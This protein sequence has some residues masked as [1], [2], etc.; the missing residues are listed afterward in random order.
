L[1]ELYW[2]QSGNPDGKG[3]V[4][5]H[6]GPGGGTEPRHRRFFD[7]RAYR[8]VLFDQRGCGRSVP[9]ASLHDNTTWHLVEDIE[10]L[11]EHLGIDRWQVFGGSWGSTLGL[12]YAQAHPDRVTELVLRGIFTFMPDEVDWFYRAGTKVL[13]PDA[14]A[15]FI[16]ALPPEERDDP[17]VNYHRRLT[18]DDPQVRR[19]AARAWSRWE[20]KVATLLPDDDLLAHCDDPTFSLAFARIEAHYFV[21][22]G[23]FT[24]PNQLLDDVHKVRSIP[25][26]IVHGRYDVICPV[27]NAWRLHRAW[28]ES[29]LV[30]VPDSG[31]SANEPGIGAALVAATDKFRGGS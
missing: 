28:P 2:E 14:Y 24:R 7:P 8:I 27:R 22:G 29:Q 5:L 11:R 23:F 30:I 10:R 12:A 26:V 3:V 18:S 20:C 1:H 17:I 6:G 21:N 19:R 16:E 9:H 15:E 25:S 13:Y 4:F 31:H